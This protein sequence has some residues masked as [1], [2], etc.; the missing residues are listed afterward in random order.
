[1]EKRLPIQNTG[2]PVPAV[3]MNLYYTGLGIARSLGRRGVPVIGLA[4]Q[5]GVYGNYS[6]YVK[7]VYGADSRDEPE[8]LLQQLLALGRRHGGRSVLFP[9]RDHDL[10][11][12]DRFRSELEPYF[13]PV[14]P[15]AAVLQRCLDKWET[16]L[17]AKQANVP[18]PECWL[19]EDAARLREIAHQISYPC[20]LKP[21]SAHLWRTGNNWELV[22][23]RKAFVVA[24][25]E[26]LLAAY[27][28][29]ARADRRV[30]VQE[31]IPGGDDRLI[32]AACYLDSHSRFLGG[33][34]TQK[35]VQTP[36][37]FGTGCIVQSAD[38][39][40][41]FDRTIRLLQAMEFSGIAEVEY[42]W[43][44]R[45]NEYKLIEINPRPWDQHRLGLACG[46]DLVHLAYC[47][48]AGLPHADVRPAFT[49]C[50]WVAED[51]LLLAALSL[52]RRREAGLGTL[53]RQARGK[54]M[55]AIWSVRDP[56]PFVMYLT[57][58][59]PALVG[60]AL[61]AMRRQRRPSAVDQQE[62]AAMRTAR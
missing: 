6:R 38:R 56:L 60:M 20:V 39:P 12:L 45:D 57:R 13:V 16:F 32:I 10:V 26:E 30:L 33:F 24:S 41:L 55:Y 5:R 52:V 37:G 62:A 36:P 18:A 58:T 4:A 3:V 27:A 49:P 34:N 9:T 40:E 44:E 50:K 15:S 59:V 11:F 25:S 19:V 22:G 47:D 17:C 7:T 23:G 51:A 43:D 61:H 8:E 29:I 53:L 54:K 2:Q 14:M 42:K 46:V 31:Q 1:M 21:L 28:V 35:L 48:R